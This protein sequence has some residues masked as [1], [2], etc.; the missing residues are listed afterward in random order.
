MRH[1]RR[2]ANHGEIRDSLRKAGYRVWDM[3]DVGGGFPDLLVLS[4]SKIG[5]LFEV[6]VKGEKLTK[7]ELKFHS[8]YEGALGIVYSA[9]QAIEIIGGYDQ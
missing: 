2:D 1:G 9:E 6:K 8:E 3:G 7:Q 5:V 4:K